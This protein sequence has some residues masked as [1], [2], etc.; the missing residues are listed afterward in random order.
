VATEQEA[1]AAQIT[2]RRS[3]YDVQ[4]GGVANDSEAVLAGRFLATRRRLVHEMENFM[5]PPQK[6][7]IAFEQRVNGVRIFYKT[8]S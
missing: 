4:T 6:I 8:T 2:H 5:F 1:R 7:E 3:R